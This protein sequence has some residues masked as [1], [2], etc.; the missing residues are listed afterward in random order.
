MNHYP[1]HIGDFNTA[2]RHLSR[3]ER[4]IYR[5]MRDMYCDTEAALDGSCFD[6][7]ARRLLCRSPEEID[8]L[9]FVLAE[10]FTQLPDGRYQNDECEQI[11]AQFRQQQEGR[12][13][14][15]SNEHLRQKRSRARRS[16]IFSALRSLGIVPTLKTQMPE[17]MALCR[18]HGIVVTDTS[19]TL[20]G[21]DWLVADTGTVTPRHSNV[22]GNDTACHGDGTGNQNQNQ[23]IPPNP[24]AG[25]ASGVTADAIKTGEGSGGLAIATALAGF[26]PEQ[27]RTRLVD[28]AEEVAAAITRGD[29]T[30]EELLAAAEK[31]RELLAAKDGKACPGL[32]RWVREQR[33]RDVVMLAHAA[34]AGQPVG[35]AD[36]RSGVEGMAASL[37]M[38]GYDDWCDARAG[39]G[40]RR[41]FADYEA[42][43][44]ALLAERQGVSA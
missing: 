33:W 12:N 6:L 25:G 44:H 27:R 8:A 32:L 7:L 21:T 35:W 10:F 37:G 39:Q 24:P 3:L 22:T 1:H 20:N 43:V 41:A 19:V 34:A 40:L 4:A 38:P 15:K 26:F 31:Q 17:L 30:A 16:A 18:K 9:Q 42:A 23:L 11:V 29:V 28:V 13:E 5:D 14:V 36:T 2:T